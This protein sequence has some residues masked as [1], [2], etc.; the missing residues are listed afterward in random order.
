MTETEE[1]GNTD[2]SSVSLRRHGNAAHAAVVAC[3]PRILSTLGAVTLGF[4]VLA[5]WF[6]FEQP[7]GWTVGAYG[8]L[9]MGAIFLWGR[10]VSMTASL[11]LPTAALG[12][13]FVG[14]VEE[15][16]RLSITLGGLGLI[17]L[18]SA[19][20]D[21]W[22]QSAV[23]WARRWV[24][25]ATEGWLCL[26]AS[27]GASSAAWRKAPQSQDKWA[28]LRRWSVAVVLGAFFVA[29]FAATN[30][31]IQGW[32]SSSWKNLA[33]LFDHL[34]SFARMVFWAVVAFQVWALMRYRSYVVEASLDVIEGG[35]PGDLAGFLSPAAILRSLLA[36][37][38]LFGI[39]TVL[40]I[41]YL[42]GDRRSLK[43]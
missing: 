22:S 37:N 23:V 3:S 16:N 8:L 27:I 7:L 15:P 29:L 38:L 17:T 14:C 25:H 43:A 39:Q 36:F 31:I 11:T 10:S 6:F 12:L 18:A 41:R 1:D 4:L 28:F 20:R 21:R 40:D 2:L 13:L 42:W 35:L 30:P 24:G 33:S 34:P 26:P 9:L 32:L 5:D 19:L